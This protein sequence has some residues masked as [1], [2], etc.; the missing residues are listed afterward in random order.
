LNAVHFHS[1]NIPL[2]PP[3]WDIAFYL[4]ENR[5]RNELRL[6]LQVEAIR[7]SVSGTRV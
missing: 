3:P 7:S 5:Y 1:A 2:P 6:Q 4:E